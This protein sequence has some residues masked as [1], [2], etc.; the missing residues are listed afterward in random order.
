MCG[1]VPAMTQE[2][3]A[4]GAPSVAKAWDF[5]ERVVVVT[6]AARGIGAAAASLFADLGATVVGCDRHPTDEFH[7][8]WAPA[9]GRP[10]G[11]R[12]ILDVRDAGAV[13]AFVGEVEERFGAVHTLV[14]NAGGT[15][16]SAFLDVSDKGEAAVIAENFTQVTHL[17]RRAVPL[18]GS[19]SSIVNITSSEAFQAAPRFAVYAAMKAALTQLTRT[20]ALELST[21]GIRVN[22]VAPDGIPT[23][24]DDVLKDDMAEAPAPFEPVVTPPLGWFAT[25]HDAATVVAFLASDLARFVTGATVNVDGGIVAA[26]GWRRRA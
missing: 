26:G 18:M 9:A 17:V 4:Q 10:G 8:R 16:V 3:G 24:G 2:G 13:D 20:L 14:N 19:G 23:A 15:F 6:G 11:L 12:R 1:S 5:S 7:D 25:P 21:L 22:A